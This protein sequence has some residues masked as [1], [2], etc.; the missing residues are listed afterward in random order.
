M[1]FL[2]LYNQFIKRKK[3]QNKF[4]TEICRDWQSIKNSAYLALEPKLKEITSKKISSNANIFYFETRK[5]S[6]SRNDFGHFLFAII[7]G[8]NNNYDN[9]EKKNINIF[10]VC[11]PVDIRKST[12][13]EEKCPFDSCERMLA[14]P[15]C[16]KK[17]NF[18]IFLKI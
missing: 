17:K 8:S 4:F 15:N 9:E 5:K 16:K 10:A 12:F 14:K 6:E 1:E 7:E 11:V 13:L 2:Y 18:I 3:G